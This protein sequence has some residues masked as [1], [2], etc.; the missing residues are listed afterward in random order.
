MSSTNLD[1]NKL[2]LKCNLVRTEKQ[3]PIYYKATS[4]FASL[5]SNDNHYITAVEKDRV[6]RSKFDWLGTYQTLWVGS[7]IL[8]LI[9]IVLI[10]LS[11]TIQD[12]PT[13]DV[14]FSIVALLNPLIHNGK[15]IKQYFKPFVAFFIV[16]SI[17]W[18]VYQNENQSW[19]FFISAFYIFATLNILLLV[20]WFGIFGHVWINRQNISDRIGDIKFSKNSPGRIKFAFLIFSSIFSYIFYYLQYKF[21][22][23][24]IGQWSDV[25]FLDL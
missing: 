14:L 22:F 15:I 1:T 21:V 2:N 10:F 23:Q 16:S 4:P 11:M 5:S 3:I 20:M 7:C 6:I 12:T 9:S 18:F 19:I 13:L 25:E 8:S 17:F 24:T